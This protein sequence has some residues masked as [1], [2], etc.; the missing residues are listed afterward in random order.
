MRKQG[1]IWGTITQAALAIAIFVALALI[2][3]LVVNNSKDTLSNLNNCIGMGG[4]LLSLGEPGKCLECKDCGC[5]DPPPG[6]HWQPL[7]FKCNKE[8]EEDTQAYCCLPIPDNLNPRSSKVIDSESCSYEH[9]PGTILLVTEENGEDSCISAETAKKLNPDD[10]LNARYYLRESACTITAEVSYTK[11]TNGE[12]Y[13]AKYESA[14]SCTTTEAYSE[15]KLPSAFEYIGKRGSIGLG[16]TITIIGI[17]GGHTDRA[18]FQL[19]EVSLSVTQEC[20]ASINP[21]CR[22]KKLP[23]GETECIT[24]SPPYVVCSN[25]FNDRCSGRNVQ[26]SAETIAR[27]SV[28][29]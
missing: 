8:K 18:T 4:A 5:V 29:V 2:V 24:Q 10:Q 13:T 20:K 3:F 17:S 16:S 25:F 26:R 6:T 7:S 28:C 27:Y 12:K 9:P 19:R 15:T 11:A 23:S 22:G 14:F 21:T 1:S